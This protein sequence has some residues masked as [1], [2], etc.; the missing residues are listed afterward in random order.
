MGKV[1]PRFSLSLCLFLPVSLCVYAVC[2]RKRRREKKARKERKSHCL[3]CLLT[4]KSPQEHVIIRGSR[5]RSGEKGEINLFYFS[6]SA[7]PNSHVKSIHFQFFTV[8]KSDERHTHTGWNIEGPLSLS[9]SWNSFLKVEQGKVKWSVK[10]RKREKKNNPPS[11][12]RHPPLPLSC[13][14]LFSF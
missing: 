13:G 12:Q 1:W 8:Y 2:M 10:Q 3:H 4:H 5:E 7:R 14:R 9:L 11:P 6:R